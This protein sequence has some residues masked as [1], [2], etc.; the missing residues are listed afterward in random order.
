MR[1]V[2]PAAADAGRRK[3][4]AL[5]KDVMKPIQWVARLTAV[6][7]ALGS[8]TAIAGCGHSDETQT[9]TSSGMSSGASGTAGRGA[10]QPG[11]RPGP[12]RSGT[13]A[14]KTAPTD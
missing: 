5:R 1:V 14:M 3:L 4:T 2:V 11:A 7:V 12:V 10:T 13:G 9:G 6:L 8:L